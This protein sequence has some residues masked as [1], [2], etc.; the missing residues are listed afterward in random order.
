[1]GDPGCRWQATGSVKLVGKADQDRRGAAQLDSSGA[2]RPPPPS[3]ATAFIPIRA[4]EITAMDPKQIRSRWIVSELRAATNIRSSITG[5]CPAACGRQRRGREPARIPAAAMQALACMQTRWHQDA[6]NRFP[7]K[8]LALPGSLKFP[9]QGGDDD[10]LRVI[11]TNAN[12]ATS[13]T[14]ISRF[15][16][17]LDVRKMQIDA[18]G[19]MPGS[20]PGI[21]AGDLDV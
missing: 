9:G 2:K 3:A 12:D 6:W 14:A 1:M 7:W 21:A 8:T 17:A 19:A 5:R 4:T 15:R 10:W 16:Q 13:C 20:D 18:N 11:C